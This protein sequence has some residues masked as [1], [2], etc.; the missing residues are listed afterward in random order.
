MRYVAMLLCLGLLTAAVCLGRVSAQ[1][2]N[3]DGSAKTTP[4]AAT[5]EL[6]RVRDEIVRLEKLVGNGGDDAAILYQLAGDFLAVGDSGRSLDALDKCVSLNVGF[7]PAEDPGFASL[8][9]DARFRAIADRAHVEPVH[10]ATPAFELPQS[11]LLPEGIAAD[12]AAGTLYIGSLNHRKIVRISRD[13][14]ISDFITD[15]QHGALAV[16]GIKVDPRDHGVWAAT[17]EAG[18]WKSLLLHLS[19]DGGLWG[20]YSVD[21][22]GGTFFNDLAVRSDGDVFIT[23]SYF[24]RVFHFEHAQNRIKNVPLV[25][26]LIG[27]NGIALSGDESLLYIGHSL[28][29]TAIDLRTGKAVDVQRPAGVTLAGIDGLCYYRD[30]LIAVQNSIGTPRIVR[31]ALTANGLGVRSMTVL[32]QGTPAAELPTTAAILGSTLY[33]MSNTQ[34]DNF[35]RGKVLDATKLRQ[36]AISKIELDPISHSA[37]APADYPF[38]VKPYS[39]LV[40]LF[41]YD[42][43]APL[44]ISEEPLLERQGVRVVSVSFATPSGG[45]RASAYLV[46]PSGKGPFPAIIL[47]HSGAGRDA[48]FPFALELAR[49][50]AIVLD[51]Q[52]TQMEPFDA[53]MRREVLD[54]RRARDLLAAR[55]DVDSDRV[56]F[57]GHSM[58]AMMGA[59]VAG[60]DHRFRCFVFEAGLSGMTFHL[61]FSPHPEIRRIRESTSADQFQSLLAGIAPYDAVHYLG[62]AAPAALLF[63]AARFDLGVSDKDYLDFFAA[64]SEPKQLKWYDTGHEMG[65]DPAVRKDQ[66]DFLTQ[67]LGLKPAGETR[68]APALAA[69]LW[70]RD[71]A[72]A[73]DALQQKNHAAYRDALVTLHDDFPGNA[74]VLHDL[75]LA[76]AQLGNDDAALRWLGQYLATGQI[77]RLEHPAFADLKQRGKL[78]SLSDAVAKNSAVAAVGAPLF[79]LTEPDLLVE[80]IAY[81]PTTGRIFLSSIHKRKILS[82]D[83]SGKCEEFFTA[84][85]AGGGPIWGMMALRVD[86]RARV[87]WATTAAVNAQEGF[88][89][90]DDGRSAVL[91]FDLRTGRL[92]RRFD[93]PEGKH[94][95]GDLTVSS[96]GDV[97][98]S[99]SVSGDVFLI[100][101]DGDKLEPLVTRG[102]FISPQTPA[103]SADEKVLFVP[104]Y[105]AGI[106]ALSLE[107]KIVRWL[108]AK[109]PAA[110]DGIDGLYTANRGLVAVQNGTRP[111]RIVELQLN[112]ELQ[113]T[114]WKA[115]EANTTWL[116]E[117]NH[118]VI[119]GNDFYFIANSGWDRVQ[120]DGAM[121][122]GKPAEVRRMR[123][124]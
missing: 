63:Q 70:S 20:K 111:K 12:S 65:Y 18:T 72:R 109:V 94:T 10:R 102:T 60:V 16:L 106:A 46:I 80:D 48:F 2:S 37:A 86:P 59:V 110:L 74:H 28:G 50:G 85:N 8:R 103:L 31:F 98:V 76:E 6:A 96:R 112:P 56:A 87:L 55:P 62:H 77:P 82:C 32:E 71:L 9:S 116:G 100:R 30:S 67:Q 54:I 34:V 104:D 38:A 61:R 95:M 13:G 43:R 107:S 93:P 26:K 115:L 51:L 33:F 108:Q 24:G 81:D 89:G 68:A 19:A 118:G 105:S 52:P 49:A 3:N 4:R 121:S 90:G 42:S 97:Y 101:R 88:R 5:D 47:V 69:Q 14:K 17:A 36:V 7:D 117:P 57:V 122:A 114:D 44:N 27:P 64:A 1:Q 99:D 78:D 53:M 29:V 75:A 39:D 120:D 23:D 119:V 73:R 45:P 35:R 123:L 113:I 83:R 58:G 15:G 84:A 92:L 11:D 124:K 41:D 91:K 22:P 79:Q 66:M 25:E 40:K 21:M